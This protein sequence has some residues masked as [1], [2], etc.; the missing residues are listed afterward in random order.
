[1]LTATMPPIAKAPINAATASFGNPD[2]VMIA[3]STSKLRA[4]NKDQ[5]TPLR[6]SLPEISAQ[7]MPPP[8]LPRE[9]KRGRSEIGLRAASALANS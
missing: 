6:R 1:M 9:S 2:R 5:A 4:M 8:P 3:A 7:V